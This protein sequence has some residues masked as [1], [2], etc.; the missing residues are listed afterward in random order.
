ME[1]SYEPCVA[2]R[3]AALREISKVYYKDTHDTRE[4]LEYLN[5]LA[6]DRY[7]VY[8]GFRGE[9]NQARQVLTILWSHVL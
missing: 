2:P 9:G 3:P 6:R 1:F 5:S 7:H 8:A 4:S